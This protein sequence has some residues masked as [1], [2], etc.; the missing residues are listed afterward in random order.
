MWS[1]VMTFYFYDLETSGVSPHKQRIIQFAG[2]RTNK[3][4]EPIG[5][6]DEHFIKLPEDIIPEPWAVLTHGITP[7][8]SN[9]DGLTEAEF[10]AWFD[11]H[12]ATENTIVVGYNNI[13]FDNEFMRYMLY[14][15]FYDPY[16]WQ[17]KDGRSTWDLMD[18]VR[19]T[20]AL[21]PSGIE[22][23]FTSKGVTT[24]KLEYITSVNNIEHGDAHKAD[25]D[26]WATIEVAKLIKN[27]QP[28]LFDY[29][30][31][32]RDKK[33]VAKLV[34]DGAPFVYTS[35][36]YSGE[37]ERTT[38]ACSLGDHPEQAGSVLVYNL[39][40]D[41]KT[42]ES[43][44]AQQLSER[45]F[46]KKD[47]GIPRL[48]VKKMALNKSPAVAPLG[49][50]DKDSWQRLGLDKGVIEANLKA[51]RSTDLA[52]R[53]KEAFSIKHKQSQA[54]FLSEPSTVD[55]QL[56]E[57]FFND[58]DKL[59]MAKVRSADANNLADLSLDF[60]DTRLGSLLPL[61]KARNFPRSLNP[62]EAQQWHS[63]LQ[64]KFYQGSTPAIEQFSTQLQKAAEAVASDS[65]KMA[66]LEDLKLYVES[67]LPEPD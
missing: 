13:R 67:I 14:R 17:W 1:G 38:I 57:G 62:E 15:N 34:S 21:R 46:V 66:L 65:K 11:E 6:I 3:D 43:L 26:V 53:L 24:V 27:A 45:I 50:L 48:P 47:S 49:V 33:S 58:R 23:P 36:R 4:L 30:L 37:F 60:N 20:R 10:L 32:M 44:S 16:E 12:V 59:S 61:Y 8:Q 2:Q 31:G 7:Q 54:V 55:A 51:L 19:M 29:L 40:E 52:L 18:V 22:W 41:P 64:S 5:D 63:Y 39:R 9:Q 35:G 42:L 28:K 25:A 56:Y